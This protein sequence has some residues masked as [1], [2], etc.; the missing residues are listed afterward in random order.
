MKTSLPERRFVDA[1]I[2]INW[3]KARPETAFRDENA[4]I[5]GYI[6][7]KIENGEEVLTTVTIKDEVAIWLSRYR[8]DALNRFLELL[9][10]Y[11]TLDIVTPTAEDQ[12]EAGKMMGRHKLNYTDLLTLRTMKRHNIKEIYTSDTGFDTIPETKRIFT[13]LKKEEG[14]NTFLNKLKELQETNRPTHP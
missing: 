10:G 5:S 12:I 1:N 3:L 11:I 9:S 14:Y 6:L 8:A 4:A 2:F 13:E 7:Q